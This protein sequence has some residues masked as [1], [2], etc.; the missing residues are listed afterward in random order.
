MKNTPVL[1]LAV[2]GM[3]FVTSGL[4]SASPLLVA[5]AAS[6]ATASSAEKAKLHSR[7]DPFLLKKCGL[8][9]EQADRFVELKLAIFAAQAELQAEMKRSGAAG[10][11]AEVEAARKKLTS[12]M[13]DE[14][15]ELLGPDGF[16]ALSSYERISAYIPLVSA[17]F[18]SARTPLSEEQANELIRLVI[19][20]TSQTRVRPTDL[21]TKMEIDWPAVANEARG[22]LSPEQ[23]ATLQ[24]YASHA[25]SGS[26]SR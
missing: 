24:N 4:A 17:I 22:L 21:G 26:G 3:A 1:R 20:N 5:A 16:A 25:S 18:D 7:Y 10:G 9:K 12:P 2:V 8:T 15:R 13:W 6:T 19:K 23:M 11:S 14:I